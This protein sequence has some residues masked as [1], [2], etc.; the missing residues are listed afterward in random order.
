MEEEKTEL[1]KSILTYLG[2]NISNKLTVLR[3]Q[4]F[5]QLEEKLFILLYLFRKVSQL[6]IIF[7]YEK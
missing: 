6:P 3:F 2:E 4:L 1:G 7:Q 5:L